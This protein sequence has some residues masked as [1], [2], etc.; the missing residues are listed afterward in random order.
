M[1]VRS[2]N[3]LTREEIAKLTA[4]T[5]DLLAE[6]AD[7]HIAQLRPLPAA[8]PFDEPAVMTAMMGGLEAAAQSS[9]E[10]C[11]LAAAVV[12]AL[13]MASAVL[14]RTDFNAADEGR[15]ARAHLH[16]IAEGARAAAADFETL[17][18]RR[19][20]ATPFVILEEGE[21]DARERE[22]LLATLNDLKQGTARV[23]PRAPAG[24]LP[25]LDPAILADLE[26]AAAGLP[27]CRGGGNCEVPSPSET[28]TGLA[29]GPKL[30][31][32]AM[33]A[34][35]LWV[36]FTAHKLSNRDWRAEESKASESTLGLVISI[37][38][39]H[40]ARHYGAAAIAEL[41]QVFQRLPA[42]Y[43]QAQPWVDLYAREGARAVAA[44]SAE[45]PL[46]RTTDKTWN[47]HFSRLKAFFAYAAS[48]LGLA[49]AAGTPNPCDGLFI[50]LDKDTLSW[51]QN[52]ER[53]RCYTTTEMTALFTAPKFTGAA[54]AS[55]WRTPGPSIVRDHRFWLTIIAFL[56]GNRREEPALLKVKHVRGLGPGELP[57]FD[58][59]DRD[60]RPLLKD[61]G[62]PREIPFHRFM[63][64]LGFLEARILH[65]DPEE[66]IF[67]DAGSAAEI[68]GD[69]GP[70]GQWFRQ[71][72]LA[73]G[74]DDDALDLHSSRHTV[75]NR[76]KEAGVPISHIEALIG[77]DTNGRRSAFAAYDR[78]MR[79]EVLK[80]AIDKLDVPLDVAAIMAAVKRSDAINPGFAWPDLKGPFKWSRKNL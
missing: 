14:G 38:G 25:R 50:A 74:V 36:R 18:A 67:P 32:A 39:D 8:D 24:V 42:K 70:F 52:W 15:L 46:E 2:Q 4:A 61:S 60:L 3:S 49:M 21:L 12:P 45:L 23:S 1:L 69:T 80:A 77:H 62:S 59:F 31:N 34:S 78:K 40:P 56:H 73:C 54:S 48:P 53:R 37:L 47:K 71:F 63:A 35:E 11:D 10:R 27:V 66:R 76:L 28:L 43:G 9:L 26:R 68:G 7:S 51:E 29:P 22:H 44:Q 20:P 65:R 13:A 64:P 6:A 57:Y 58:L 41:R 30:I 16:G 75:F 17:A 55:R 79:I 5:V 33:P 19:P 72:R